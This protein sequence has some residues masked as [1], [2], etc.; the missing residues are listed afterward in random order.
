MAPDK[1]SSERPFLS[2]AFIRNVSFLSGIRWGGV[3]VFTD[4]LHIVYEHS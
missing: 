3:M 2:C 1:E 4:K